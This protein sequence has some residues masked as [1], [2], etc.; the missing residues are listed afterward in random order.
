MSDIGLILDF[1]SEVLNLVCTITDF[2]KVYLAQITKQKI[3]PL[4]STVITITDLVM[5]CD[6][7]SQ[8]PIGRRKFQ[9]Q[10]LKVVKYH[11]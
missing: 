1:Y 8:S 7:F 10:V 2:I 6:G 3:V 5:F 9:R 11:F 4:M